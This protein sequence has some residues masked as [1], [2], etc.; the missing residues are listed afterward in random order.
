MPE[1]ADGGWTTRSPEHQRRQFWANF[2]AE[3]AEA[4]RRHTSGS[5]Q[6]RL[7]SLEACVRNL[8]RALWQFHSQ[9]LAVSQGRIGLESRLPMDAPSAAVTPLQQFNRSAA[10]LAIAFSRWDKELD[11]SDYDLLAVHTSSVSYA[12]HFARCYALLWRE[13]TAGHLFR[14]EGLL[15]RHRLQ[16]TVSIPEC[17]RGWFF[18]REIRRELPGGGVEIGGTEEDCSAKDLEAVNKAANEIPELRFQATSSRDARTT[19]ALEPEKLNSLLRSVSSE[20]LA[21]SIAKAMRERVP[22]L[23]DEASSHLSLSELVT[24]QWNV[25]LPNWLESLGLPRNQTLAAQVAA[26]EWGEF[27]MSEDVHQ[28]PLD[29]YVELIKTAVARKQWNIPVPQ[30]SVRQPPVAKTDSDERFLGISLDREHGIVVRQGI[31]IAGIKLAGRSLELF[32]KFFDAKS[33]GVPSEALNHTQFE[34]T[35]AKQAITKLR[36]ELQALGLTITDG[37]GGKNRVLTSTSDISDDSVSGQLT[38]LG[39]PLG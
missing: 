39:N 3:L 36:G 28:I 38:I 29:N 26:V 13:V 19:S 22:E 30:A 32:R 37:R 15:T 7:D 14:G 31:D 21:E 35:A 24:Y 33:T 34:Q 8:H 16:M 10:A 25:A 12:G 6:R 17:Q 1:S 18:Y 11:S 9:R 2:T 20:R 5:R 27:M 23:S 4:R